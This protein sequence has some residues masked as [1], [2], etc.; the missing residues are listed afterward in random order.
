MPKSV[1]RSKSQSPKEKRNFSCV[2]FFV[3]DTDKR[4]EEEQKNAIN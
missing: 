1:L 4:L 2:V 3:V